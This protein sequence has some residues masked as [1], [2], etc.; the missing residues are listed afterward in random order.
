MK[1]TGEET[2]LGLYSR[3]SPNFLRRRPAPHMGDGERLRGPCRSVGGR[4]P[5]ARRISPASH[6][7]PADESLAVGATLVVARGRFAQPRA[8]RPHVEPTDVYSCPPQE[9]GYSASEPPKADRRPTVSSDERNIPFADARVALGRQPCPRS[10]DAG[11]VW[12][13]EASG[14]SCRY[15]QRLTP[16]KGPFHPNVIDDSDGTPGGK[17]P[18]SQY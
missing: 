1:A 10:G 9:G 16:L 12:T 6:S 8:G 4:V 3:V 5:G 15:A 18:R 7:E 17:E 14:L 13:T 11:R 2:A